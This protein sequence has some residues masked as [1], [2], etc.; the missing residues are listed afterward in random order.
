MVVRGGIEPPISHGI[1]PRA[2]FH[3]R[4]PIIKGAR[5]L[6]LLTRREFIVI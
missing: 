4:L 5:P 6:A 3:N 1:S 2:R